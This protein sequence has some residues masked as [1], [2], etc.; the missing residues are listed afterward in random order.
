MLKNGLFRNAGTPFNW[1]IY[2]TFGR[3]SLSKDYVGPNIKGKPAK[4]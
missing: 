1:Y 4:W 3:S 2:R